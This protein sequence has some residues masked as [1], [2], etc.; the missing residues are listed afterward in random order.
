MRAMT[1][2]LPDARVYTT[3]HVYNDAMIQQLLEFFYVPWRRGLSLMCDF[4]GGRDVLRYLDYA[5]GPLS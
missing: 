4:H 3:V 5:H 2:I 1:L